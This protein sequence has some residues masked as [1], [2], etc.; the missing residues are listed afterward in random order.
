MD[1]KIKVGEF[2]VC[3]TNQGIPIEKNRVSEPD[4]GI[5]T[6]F[7]YGAVG[8]VEKIYETNSEVYLIGKDQCYRIPNDHL[9]PLDPTKT[10]KGYDKKICNLCHVLKPH[11]EFEINQ[12]DAKGRK[13]SRPS[14]RECRKSIDQKP[15]TVAA[16]KK[17]EKMRPKKGTLWRCPICRKRSIVGITAKVVLDHRHSDGTAR[18]FLCDSCNTGLGRFKNGSNYLKNAITYL[19][20]FKKR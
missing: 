6:H 2:V 10:G 17:A 1:D 14:C 18:G 13:T 5:P 7:D 9:A 16:K 20:Q 11:S 8:I 15:M 12:T 3:N 4:I 19:A